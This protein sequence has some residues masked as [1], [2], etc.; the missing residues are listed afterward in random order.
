MEQN[1]IAALQIA[2][3]AVILDMGTVAWSGSAQDVL[4]NTEL[5]HQ[6]LAV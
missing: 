1:A 4:E 6:Y 3:K 2:D 5:R